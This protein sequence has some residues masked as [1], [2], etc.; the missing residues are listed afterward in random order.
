MGNA[1]FYLQAG[2]YTVKSFVHAK[3]KV[4]QVTSK[5]F[6]V[7]KY[8]PPQVQPI[9]YPTV[10]P[11]APRNNSVLGRIFGIFSSYKSSSPQV[12]MSYYDHP[13]PECESISMLQSASLDSMKISESSLRSEARSISPQAVMRPHLLLLLFLLASLNLLHLQNLLPRNSLCPLEEL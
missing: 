12:P 9:Q 1:S 8:V 10:Q 6:V 13:I 7:E 2:T 5:V 4:P 11:V 3:S